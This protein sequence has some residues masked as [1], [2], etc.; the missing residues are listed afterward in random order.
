MRTRRCCPLVGLV[1][2]AIV[3]VVY[4]LLRRFS[5]GQTMDAVELASAARIDAGGLRVEV[6]GPSRWTVLALLFG[7]ALDVWLFEPLRQL[8]RLARVRRD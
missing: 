1:V 7:R 4:G 5:R 2:C 6:A 8:D 3:Y